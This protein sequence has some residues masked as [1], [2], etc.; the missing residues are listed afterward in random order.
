MSGYKHI[1][2]AADLI[3]ADDNLVLKRVKDLKKQGN[4]KISIIHS[5]E[6]PSNY[7]ESY[8]VPAFVEWQQ[9]LENSAKERM[10]K[11]SKDLSIA[12]EDQH[13]RIGQAKYQILEV[14]E[15]VGADLIVVGSHARHGLGLLF[16]G[17]TANAVLHHAKCDVLAVRV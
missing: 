5:V 7:G 16:L 17:S 13:L 12:K 1:L 11:I 8:E 14:A 10:I 9:E 3:V 15:E 6:Y 4:P 2:V